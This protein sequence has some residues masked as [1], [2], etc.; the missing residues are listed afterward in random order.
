MSAFHVRLD[1]LERDL[2]RQ[3]NDRR[4]HNH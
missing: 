2:Y 3:E 4:T 1:H